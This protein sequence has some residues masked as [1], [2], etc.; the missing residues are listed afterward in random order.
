MIWAALGMKWSFQ[1]P[2]LYHFSPVRI[3]IRDLGGLAVRGEER[4]RAEQGCLRER[5]VVRVLHVE[6]PLDDV[7]RVEVGARGVVAVLVD[8]E[9]HAQLADGGHVPVLALVLVTDLRRRVRQAGLVEEVLVEVQVRRV[10]RERDADRG[11][12]LAELEEVDELGVDAVDLVAGLV[13]ERLQV[14]ELVAEEVQALDAD[15]PD[16]VRRVAR[17]DLGL[18]DVRRDVVVVDLEGDVDVLLRLVVGVDELRLFLELLRLTAR[19]E[20][21]EPADD[22]A[23]VRARGGRVDRRGGDRR[24]RR[25]A[26]RP[27][28]AMLGRLPPA[29][30]G[31]AAPPQAPRTSMNPTN[32][33]DDAGRA[34]LGPTCASRACPMTPPTPCPLIRGSRLSTSSLSR[35]HPL[36]R[37]PTHELRGENHRPRHGAGIG[38]D[39]RR[40]GG[41]SRGPSPRSAVERW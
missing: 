11:A 38:D 32:R 2:S 34:A 23:A 20:S 25:S 35:L 21:D 26:R 39:A 3:S 33:T 16:E 7:L 13:D 6:A 4:A 18:E 27:P 9:L 36:A 24:R 40:E 19:A 1:T 10:G 14:E 29:G 28:P 22:D 17:G 12:A 30:A 37:P 8:G 31:E 15:R 5:A 41:P